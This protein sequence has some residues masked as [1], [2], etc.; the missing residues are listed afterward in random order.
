MLLI[1]HNSDAKH[2]VEYE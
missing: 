1:T 2:Q